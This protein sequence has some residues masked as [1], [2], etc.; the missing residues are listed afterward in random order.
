MSE[1]DVPVM[2][3]DG[4]RY[5][6]SDL[7]EAQLRTV[8]QIRDLEDQLRTNE[9]KHDQLLHG[10]S[11]YIAELKHTLENPDGSEPK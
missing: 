6:L 1:K 7:N 2:T 11:A 8:D 9:F 3:I 5:A 10:R 4:T